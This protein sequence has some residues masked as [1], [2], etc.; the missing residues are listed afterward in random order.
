LRH[1]LNLDCPLC[2]SFLFRTQ[3]GKQ[4]FSPETRKLD[5]LKSITLDSSDSP[6]VRTILSISKPITRCCEYAPERKK[7]DKPSLDSSSQVHTAIY[8]RLRS[9]LN[10][11]RTTPD[12]QTMNA[13]M[14]CLP[15][16]YQLMEGLSQVINPVRYNPTPM[17]KGGE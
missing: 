14:D 15:M 11:R 10:D 12:S 17:K 6:D 7:K 3:A 9:I 4:Q 16:R 13:P 8:V 2:K 5:Y 1:P